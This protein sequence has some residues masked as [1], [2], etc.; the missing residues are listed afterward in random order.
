MKGTPPSGR[1]PFFVAGEYRFWWALDSS[2]AYRVP[3]SAILIAV[4]EILVVLIA[5]ALIGAI[6]FALHR[7]WSLLRMPLGLRRQLVSLTGIGL[8]LWL[9]LLTL[10]VRNAYLDDLG[11]HPLRMGWVFLPP[12]VTAFILLR[13]R[14][15]RVALRLLPPRWLVG[16]QSYRVFTEGLFYLGYLGGFIPF[17]MTFFGFNQDVIVGLTAPLGAFAF[18]YA[19]RLRRWQAMYWNAFGMLLLFN[20]VSLAVLSSP[21]RFR[22]F[23]NEPDSSWLTIGPFVWVLGFIVPFGLAMHLFSIKQLWRR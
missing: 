4:C 18:F 11:A 17:Q 19:G 22:L 10:L 7:V 16:V 20:F 8:L 15:L 2:L 23:P 9:T 5:F 14:F 3:E 1:V 13:S 12:V 21:T 6:L